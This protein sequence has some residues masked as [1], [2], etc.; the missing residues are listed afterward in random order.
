MRAEQV[1]RSRGSGTAAAS[2]ALRCIRC[3]RFTATASFRLH[4]DT[5]AAPSAGRLQPLPARLQPSMTHGCSIRA[6]AAAG[7][8]RLGMLGLGVLEVGVSGEGHMPA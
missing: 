4:T 3:I 2:A 6:A 8:L 1:L 5:V 7:G